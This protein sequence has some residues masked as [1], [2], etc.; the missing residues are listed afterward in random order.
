MSRAVT[1][2]AL[3]LLY[4]SST[5]CES[6]GSSAP[7]SALRSQEAPVAFAVVPR[8]S[9][10]P[11]SATATLPVAEPPTPERPPAVRVAPRTLAVSWQS[12]LGQ[13]I[14]LR[15]RPVRRVDFMRTLIVADGLR[16]VIVGSPEVTPCG[17]TTSTFTVVGSASVA[18]AGRTVLPELLLDEGDGEDGAR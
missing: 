16:F 6:G 14:Q 7:S 9:E 18:I 1:L 5:A 13:R 10:V 4:Y 15:C 8:A 12:Y 2:L 3:L 17:A 11:P